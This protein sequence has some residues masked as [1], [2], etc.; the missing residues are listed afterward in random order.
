MSSL[1]FIDCLAIAAYFAAVAAIVLR[2]AKKQ[3]S[4]E[5]CLA[6][7]AWATLTGPMRIDLGF[8]YT[9][10]PILIGAISHFV[11]FTAAHAASRLAGDPRG[12]LEGLTVHTRKAASG[13][14]L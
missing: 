5:V 1:N 12:D 13:A 11:L 10:N 4:T 14:K 8:N 2:A 7:V 9:M 6:F 3:T